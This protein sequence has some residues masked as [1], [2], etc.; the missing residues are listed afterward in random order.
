M[1]NSKKKPISLRRWAI[2]HK[3]STFYLAI[4]TRLAKLYHKNLRKQNKSIIKISK[5]LQGNL[6]IGE[7]R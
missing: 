6:A 3:A 1:K 4:T 5:N 7:K 2:S